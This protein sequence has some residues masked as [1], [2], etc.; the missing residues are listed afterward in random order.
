MSLV[1]DGWNKR[2]ISSKGDYNT[3][4]KVIALGVIDNNIMNATD[5]ME[6][7]K[8]YNKLSNS[9]TCA[10]SASSVQGMVDIANEN[11]DCSVTMMIDT[12]E[13]EDA[14]TACAP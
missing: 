1:I 13:I 5:A 10:F 6:V 9:I 2:K 3:I 4:L 8:Q 14:M 12:N 11:F 7:I